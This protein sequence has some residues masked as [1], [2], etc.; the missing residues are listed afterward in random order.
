MDTPKSD[1]AGS[2]RPGLVLLAKPRGSGARLLPEQAASFEITLENRTDAAE[3]VLAVDG[4]YHTPVVRALDATGAVLFHKTSEDLAER[5]VPHM[6]SPGP[7]TLRTITL[8]PGAAESLWINL[9]MYHDPLPLGAYAFQASHQARPGEL[10]ESPR[11]PFEIVAARVESAALGY[12]SSLRMAS[13]LAWI[14]APSDGGGA[15]RLLLRLSAFGNHASIQQGANEVGEAPEG[16]RVAVSHIPRDGLANWQGWVAV[17]GPQRA[18]LVRHH[19]ARPGRRRVAVALPISDA[20]PV[21]RFPD[22]G[23]A[24]FLA[25]GRGPAGPA[26]V[27]FVAPTSGPPHPVWSVPLPESP[28]LTACVAGTSGPITVFFSADDG[29][30]SRVYRLDVDESGAV[31]AGAV[32]ARTTPNRVIALA[33]DQR[34]D[35]IPALV[36][37]EENRTLFDRLALVRLPLS[38]APPPIVPLAPLAGWP[39]VTENRVSRALRAEAIHLEVGMDGVPLAALVDERGRLFGGRLD[40]T[41]LGLLSDGGGTKALFPHV[42]A[43]QMGVFASCFTERGYLFHTRGD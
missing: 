2:S 15:P 43:L 18:E 34:P 23:H 39:S 33:V 3:S 17:V 21:P 25:T 6:G 24:V 36:I 32:V 10:F 29:Q 4:N 11:I 26:L 16:G 1:P 27:G 38:G 42:A 14:A 20:V 12:D 22:R 5:L 28:A 19:M 30:W 9:W 37:L 31:V 41:P 35:E 13:I 7:R 8:A 40:G